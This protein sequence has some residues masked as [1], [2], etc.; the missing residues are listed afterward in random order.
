MRISERKQPAA[1]LRF[2]LREKLDDDFCALVGCSRDL[3]RKL[4]NG[5]RK[6]TERMAAQ[7]EAATG[8]S[9][10]WLLAA[11][12]KAKPVGIDGQPYTLQSF[13]DFQA[14]QLKGERKALAL[15]VYPGGYLPSLVATA[16]S[17]AKQF[18]LASFAVELEAAVSSL[19]QR[20]GFSAEVFDAVVR[21]MQT[22][23]GAY[24]FET[25]DLQKDV[26]GAPAARRRQALACAAA[27]AFPIAATIQHSENGKSR[28]TKVEMICER[29]SSLPSQKEPRSRGRKAKP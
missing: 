5:D 7:V 23:A 22:Q 16:H 9:R 8:V 27:G 28:T 6:M 20:Y 24:L 29:L 25:V 11:N 10:V 4:E 1:V 3:W 2:I 19:R 18:K 26:E 21:D 15:A 17:A 14:A 12:A 13:R